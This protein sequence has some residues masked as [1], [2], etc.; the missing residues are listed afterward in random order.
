MPTSF[1][2]TYSAINK[3]HKVT[4]YTERCKIWENVFDAVHISN[5]TKHEL[6]CLQSERNSQ[7]LLVMSF[8]SDIKD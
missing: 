3:N 1:S 7:N 2:I 5:D 6:N 8:P 4:H